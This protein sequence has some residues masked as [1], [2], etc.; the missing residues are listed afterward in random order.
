ME[1]DSLIIKTLFKFYRLFIVPI[2]V[3]VFQIRCR[4]NES[5]SHYA[6]RK[7]NE[8]GAFKGSI[9]GLIRFLKCNP[10]FPTQETNKGEISGS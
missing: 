1:N 6:E 5:C 9:Y 4:F 8:H 7:I 2:F 3:G 10:W